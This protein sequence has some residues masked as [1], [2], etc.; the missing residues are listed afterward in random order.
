MMGDCV[1]TEVDRRQARFIADTV[2]CGSSASSLNYYYYYHEK[3]YDDDG[4]MCGILMNR[5]RWKNY[6]IVCALPC[7][8]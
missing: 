1:W 7:V 6:D 8:V 3:H 4:D 2:P 5:I